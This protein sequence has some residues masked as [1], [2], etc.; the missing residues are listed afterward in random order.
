MFGL[1]VGNIRS[2]SI[3]S[4]VIC[5]R[6]PIV[7]AMHIFWTEDNNNVQLYILMVYSDG[8]MLPSI[9]VAIVISAEVYYTEVFVAITT[10]YVQ[11]STHRSIWTCLLGVWQG[12]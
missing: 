12:K 1:C 5:T 3:L 9:L 8:H 6:G 2:A 10:H 11:N 7:L 4:I